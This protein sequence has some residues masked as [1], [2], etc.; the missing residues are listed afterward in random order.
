L[1]NSEP[2]DYVVSPGK[3][4]LRPA[5]QC[6]S[7]NQDDRPHG[8][9]PA[10]V[11][12][13][14]ISLPPGE[15][16][17]EYIQALF[18][19]CLDKNAHPYFQEIEGLQVSAH[20]LIRRDGELIQF[21]PFERRAWHAGESSFRGRNSCNDFSIGIELEGSDEVPYTDEQYRH[22]IAV[23]CA[24]NDAYPDMSSRQIAGHCDV[25]P[26]RKTDPGPAFD[27]LRLYDG[28]ALRQSNVHGVPGASLT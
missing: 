21:V 18:T 15:Y 13:H 20:V 12:L 14:G 10:L 11:I 24:I 2:V 8:V 28:L 27:W 22:L 1:S 23:I 9:S 17:G 5:L 3:G 19:N 16:G 26:E 25:A 4:L 7:P 6:P